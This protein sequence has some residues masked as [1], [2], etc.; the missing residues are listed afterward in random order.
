MIPTLKLDTAIKQA[1]DAAILISGS[2]R[3]GTTVLGKLIHSFSG[4]EYI[5]EPP[6]VIMLFALLEKLPESTWRL[7]YEAYLG[8]EFLVNAL[9][10]RQINTNHADDSSIWA[11]KPQQ[12][13]ERRLGRSWG[14]Q[15][16]RREATRSVLAYK[17]PNLV[18]ML[19]QF[20]PRYPDTRLVVIKRGAAET[21]NSLMQ[22]GWFNEF[23]AARDLHWPFREYDGVR[24]PYWVGF[25]DDELWR[26]LSEIDR[27]AYYYLRMSVTPPESDNVLCLC[28]TSLVDQPMQTAQSLADWLGL[29]FGEKTSEVIKTIRPT[30]KPVDISIFDRI[31]SRFRDEVL[32]Y[33]RLA[34][35]G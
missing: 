24:I 25:G 27:C 2:G 32:F 15:E 23:S 7:I 19:G 13:I 3:S 8:E 1:V 16:A 26:S 18:P 4:V 10:G 6:T 12:E 22:K 35:G 29:S 21:I 9:A 5:F 34:E 28:Y 31:S 11:V 30:G 14:K 20:H 17:I 33:S